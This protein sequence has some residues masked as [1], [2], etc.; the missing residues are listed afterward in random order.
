M[1]SINHRYHK[2]PVA[3]FNYNLLNN[4]QEVWPN[5]RNDGEYY[6]DFSPVCLISSLFHSSEKSDR[7]TLES[8]RGAITAH[9][10]LSHAIEILKNKWKVRYVGQGAG[11]VFTG[12]GTALGPMKNMMP[13]VHPPVKTYRYKKCPTI[14]VVVPVKIVEP[15]TEYFCFNHQENVPWDQF[16]LSTVTSVEWF[17]IAKD[18]NLSDDVTR[19]KLPDAGEYLVVEFDSSRDFHWIENISNNHYMFFVIDGHVKG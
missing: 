1:S 18:Y 16:D 12:N 2:A 10:D 9:Y 19:I 11:V 7:V 4:P 15:V 5:N 17:K 3:S 6:K 14:T 8:I 13:H